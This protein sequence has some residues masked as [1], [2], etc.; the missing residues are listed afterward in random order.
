MSSIIYGEQALAELPFVRLLRMISTFSL[1]P[2]LVST[3]YRALTFCL[4]SK[5]P[6]N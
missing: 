6:W 1:R 4:L 3:A 5:S 2:S